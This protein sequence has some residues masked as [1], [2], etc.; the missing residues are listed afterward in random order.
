MHPWNNITVKQVI[1]LPN[2]LDI[3]SKS[4]TKVTNYLNE[5]TEK[6]N[7]PVKTR[8]FKHKQIYEW[9]TKNHIKL[10]PI[11]IRQ[12]HVGVFLASLKASSIMLTIYMLV[13]GMVYLKAIA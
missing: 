12:L 8:S 10:W 6:N 11:A 3:H 4:Q 1:N 7:L 13:H 2:G 5:N 9:P